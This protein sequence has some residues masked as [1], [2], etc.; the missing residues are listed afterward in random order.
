MI[1]STPA[2]YFIS[3]YMLR[4]YTDDIMLRMD[5][6]ILE[7]RKGSDKQLTV[8]A[9][10]VLIAKL[11]DALTE[12]YL[13][14]NALSKR[15]KVTRATVDRYRPLADELI[16]KFKVD[17]NVIRNLQIKRTYLIVEQLMKDL[18]KTKSVKER[19]LVYSSIYKFSSHLALITGLNVETHVNIDPT[20][21]VIIR[22]NQ[23]KNTD[24]VIEAVND[25]V[26]KVS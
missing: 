8:A 3:G 11:V 21:L 14:T 9:R 12:G 1:L 24:R 6:S 13:S 18:E 5:E 23:K 22:S 17:R 7:E 4:L 16:G 19:A 10:N 25:T 2:Q 26:G 15:L 20:K